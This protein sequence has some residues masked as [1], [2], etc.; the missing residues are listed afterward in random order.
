[1]LDLIA[2]ETRQLRRDIVAVIALVVIFLAA[3]LAVA[4]GRALLTAQQAGR[5]AAAAETAKAEAAIAEKFAEPMEPT[6]AIYLPFRINMGIAAPLPPLLDASAGR[7]GFDSYATTANLRARA[8][9]LFKRTQLGTPELLARGSFDLGFV[10]IIIAPL[11]LIGLGHGVFVADRDSGTARLVLAQAGGPGRLLLARSLPRLVLVIAPL[12]LAL[13]WLLMAGPSVPGRATSA[14]SWGLVVLLYLALWW[15]IILFANTLRITAEPAA[16]ALV[17]AWALV[18]LVLPALITA[19]AQIAYPPPSRFEQIAA[20]RAAEIAATSAW[21][22]DHKK[23]PAGDVAGAIADLRRSVAIGTSV[24]AAVTPI[25]QAFDDRLERQQTAVATLSLL[26]PARIA[27]DA[28]AISAG[29]DSASALAFR[30]SAAAYVQ[31][32]KAPMIQLAKDGTAITTAA[33]AALPRYSP[34]PPQ[35]APFAAIIYLAAASSAIGLLAA[36]R[37]SGIRLD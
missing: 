1:M 10:A 16:L 3:C 36:R 13:G 18:T 32:L 25:N 33:Y 24:E 21:D 4:N 31:A 15:A 30:R 28:L 23:P 6:D 20:A 11:L 27:A 12:L 5:E 37:F 35:P 17:S 14:L 34:P 8:A 22:N 9:T 26:S 7:A 2:I 29:T 19:I